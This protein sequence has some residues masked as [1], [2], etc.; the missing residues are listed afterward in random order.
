MEEEAREKELQ[1]AVAVCLEEITRLKAE[2]GKQQRQIED[3]MQIQKSLIS[4][5]MNM[6]DMENL[7]YEWNDPKVD[8]SCFY[9]P[10]FYEIAET[11]ESLVCGRRSMA[12]FGDGEFALMAGKERCR[13]QRFDSR[14]AERL[15]EVIHC[16]EEGFLIGIPD[17]YGSLESYNREGKYGIRPYMTEEARREHRKFLNLERTYHNAYVSRPYAMYA[18]NK[19]DAPQKRFR[20]LQRIWDGRNILFVE[21]ALTRLGVGNDLFKNAASIRRIEA[22]PVNAWD[23]YDE[24]LAA[25]LQHANPD[26]LVLIALGPSAGVLAY[27]L[28]RSGRQALDIGHVDL[29]YEWFLRGTGCRCAVEYKYNNELVGGNRVEDIYDEEYLRQIVYVVG[30]GDSYDG[31]SAS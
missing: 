22:A 13:F 6:G 28:Y 12:R 10:K 3:F 16:E 4:A 18:D 2:I 30:G 1:K 19:T 23:A 11:V 17:Q 26:N 25:A 5:A 8:R 31:A 29:E 24:I 15:R 27:D 14:L 7:K 9:Y 20:D 21:G